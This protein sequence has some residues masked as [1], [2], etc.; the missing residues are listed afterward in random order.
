MITNYLSPIG[1]TVSVSRLPHVEFFTQKAQIPGVTL[2]AP[3]LA[4]PMGNLFVAG[5]RLAYQDLD[6]S[7][8]V[9]EN[10]D[11]YIE[12]YNW[13]EALSSPEKFG[14]YKPLQDSVEGLN[15]DI[16][17]MILNSN[18]NLN[19]EFTF[20]NCTP[21]ALSAISLDVSGT[22]IFYPEVNMSFRYDRYTFK[23]FA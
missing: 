17:I 5:D 20:L 16:S 14:D 3:Q 19:V 18:K 1:F 9:D 12:A 8:L 22:D 10:M 4:N 7:F 11:N 23:K 15:S 13:M 6:L 21:V 2:E